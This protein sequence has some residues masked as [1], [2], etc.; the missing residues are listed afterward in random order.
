MEIVYAASYGIVY[1]N[2][3]MWDCRW[4]AG[5]WETITT[6]IPHYITFFAKLNN[7]LRII[8]TYTNHFRCCM[9]LT[10]DEKILLT[11]VALSA[12]V[13]GIGIYMLIAANAA[14]SVPSYTGMMITG[15]MLFN[16]GVAGVTSIGA[17]WFNYQA[18]L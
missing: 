17:M 3:Y 10:K 1:S 18:T 12:G 11:G 15:A 6:I 14:I 4:I 16:A 8:L 9:S 7:I 13:S 5:Y 2:D